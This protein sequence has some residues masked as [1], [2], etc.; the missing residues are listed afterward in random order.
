MTV[1]ILPYMFNKKIK[2]P[3]CNYETGKFLFQR[4]WTTQLLFVDEVRCP[5]C[6]GIFRIYYGT[7]KDGTQIAYTIPKGH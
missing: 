4:E 2:C 7:K 1:V 5:S 3:F 6:Q